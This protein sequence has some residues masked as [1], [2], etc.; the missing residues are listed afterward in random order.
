MTTQLGDAAAPPRQPWAADPTT[1]AVAGTLAALLGLVVAFVRTVAV[2]FVVNDLH[3]L[4]PEVAAG[5]GHDPKD[6]WPS[7]EPWGPLSHLTGVMALALTPV[8]ALAALGWSVLALVERSLAGRRAGRPD[9]VPAPRTRALLL[10]VAV[11][12]AA[13]AAAWWSPPVRTLGTWLMD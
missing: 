6:L 1:W 5:G 8:V 13:V 3:L 7:D 4:A 12:A 9:V 2:P 10:T 11:V